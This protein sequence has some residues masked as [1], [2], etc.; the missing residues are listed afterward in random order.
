MLPANK[1][2]ILAV[3][4]WGGGASVLVAGASLLRFPPLIGSSIVLGAALSVANVYSIVLVVEAL[5]AAAMSG[6]VPSGVG[7]VMAGMVHVLKLLVITALLVALVVF[8]LAD[9]FGLLAG[10]TIVL[11]THVLQGLKRFAGDA[12]GGR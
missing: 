3:A 9:L 10:F 8:K 5:T 1:K 11:V 6:Q 4:L 2:H 7:K 12:D